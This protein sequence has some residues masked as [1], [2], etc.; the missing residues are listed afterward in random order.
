MRDLS[1]LFSPRSIAVVGASSNLMGLAGRPIAY[2]SESNLDIAVY[3]VN[4][5]R[6]EIGG[7]QVY[8][9]PASLPEAPDVGL[10][11]VP[12]AA[13]VEAIEALAKRGTKAAVVISSGFGEGDR[14]EGIDAQVRMR[15]IAREHGML[16]LGPNT[17]GVHDYVRGLPLSFVWYGRKS[18]TDEGS[19]A[20]VSQSG[21]GMTSLCDRM[22]DAGIPLGY[23]VA[24]GNE[25]D[26]TI[27]DILEHLAEDPKVKVIATV[28]EEI[29]EGER[30]LKVCQRL[31]DLGK[32]LIAMKVGRTESGSAMVK[33]HT[34][35]LAG[36]YPT[37]R[38]LMRQYGVLEVT[39]L[40]QIPGM[41]AVAALGKLPTSNSIAVVT[42]SGGA[43]A[44]SADRADELGVVLAELSPSTQVKVK[45][46]LPPFAQDQPVHNPIDV[47]AQSM[48]KRFALVDIVEALVDDEGVG[49]VIHAVPSS[50]GPEGGQWVQKYCGLSHSADK[51]IVGVILSG[52]ESD[53]LRNALR[54][55]GVPILSS[56]GQA[57]E[58]IALLHR[59][60]AAPTSADI[61][62]ARQATSAK[63]IPLPQVVTEYSTLNWLAE[64]GIPVA[65]QRMASTVSEAVAVADEIG[66][67]VAVKISSPDIAHKT[68]VGGVAL[69]LT[70]AD[71][72][73]EATTRVLANA[74]SAAPRAVLEGVTISRMVKPALEL[75]SGI[76]KDDTFG[77]VILLGLG[78]I[79]AEILGDVTMRGLPLG[80]DAA[81]RMVD[82]L[83][84]APLLR[85]ARG[86]TPV[87]MESLA[88]V[89]DALARI[90]D[91]HGDSISGLDLN[92]VAVTEDGE[93]V[94]LD[95]S[96]FISNE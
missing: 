32:P 2:L 44:I 53:H 16:L 80:P 91:E 88:R 60:A 23:G 6:D 57:V 24:T 5:T 92:P 90:I 39:D 94:V 75:I 68:E 54:D 40:D 49:A 15:D 51:P 71:E 59:F 55:G 11:V 52:R 93:L 1:P 27:V 72:V 38:A 79:W 84:G 21:S 12:A 82:D 25:A 14:A 17:L 87:K 66:Y 67:P 26:V 22:L 83:Q 50:G 47:T 63:S 33:S 37:L 7:Y 76:H 8:P 20:V 28:F 13:V 35:A 85:G 61:S 74:A 48:Q 56:P 58:A 96:L 9:D 4:P 19:V 65:T 62:A 42:N 78:G 86:R 36:S 34:G 81:R 46:N 70:T 41:V 31:R 77:H 29:R 30:F 69:S 18:R 3:P 64:Y 73:A 95:A 45:E 89:I 43:A 10:V